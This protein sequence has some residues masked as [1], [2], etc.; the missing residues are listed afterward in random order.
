MFDHELKFFQSVAES[1][2]R[3]FCVTQNSDAQ[4]ELK[5]LRAHTVLYNKAL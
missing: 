3:T 2:E 1:F 5:A 4:W